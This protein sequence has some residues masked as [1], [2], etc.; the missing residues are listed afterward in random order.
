[1]RLTVVCSLTFTADG[2]SGRLSLRLDPVLVW[3][4]SCGEVSELWFGYPKSSLRGSPRHRQMHLF[5][6]T[7]ACPYSHDGACN[8]LPG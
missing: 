4:L 3:P 6:K 8:S 5:L 1:M 2:G 7:F